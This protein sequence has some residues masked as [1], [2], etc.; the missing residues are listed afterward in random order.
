MPCYTLVSYCVLNNQ[1]EYNIA[2]EVWEYVLAHKI[3][4][5][6]FNPTGVHG[7][8]LKHNIEN[9]MNIGTKDKGGKVRW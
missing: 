3:K 2:F 1:L 7:Q 4:N 8:Y 5:G 6:T 9:I